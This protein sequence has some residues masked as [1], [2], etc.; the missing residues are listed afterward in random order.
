MVQHPAAN[1]ELT[2]RQ[3]TANPAED[4]VVRVGISADGEYLA[5][6]DLTGIHVRRIDTRETHSIPPEEGHCFR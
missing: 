3:V 6:T 5:Y 1:C 2:S 4:P